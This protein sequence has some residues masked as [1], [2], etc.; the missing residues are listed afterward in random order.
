MTLTQTVPG[1]VTFDV[2]VADARR[3]SPSL[4]RVTFSGT[5]LSEMDPGG[6]LGLRD[7]RIKLVVPDRPGHHPSADLDVADPGWYRRWLAIDPAVRGHLRTYTARRL[8]P[9]EP[10]PLLEVDFVIHLDADGSGGPASTWATQA[11]AGQRL[12]LLGPNRRHPDPGGFEWRPTS[13]TEDE[14]QRVLLVG[15][16]TALPAIGAI[17]ERLP[18]QYVGEAIVEVPCAE[19]AQELVTPPGF[20]VTYLPRGGRVR[21]AATLEALESRLLTR[22]DA[23]DDARKDAA[24]GDIGTPDGTLE[25]VLWETPDAAPST[26]DLYAWV[27]GEASVVREVRRALVGPHGL[28]RAQVAF[29]GYW[30]QGRAEG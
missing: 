23:L 11:S 24:G 18:R 15:D 27:A 20:Q 30:R 1:Y 28:S 4:V 22:R 17:L 19:D 13:T 5:D 2:E 21:G 6:P 14:R 3:L 29:M 9:A 12:T 25:E 7:T 8:V 10:T 16:E 26:A